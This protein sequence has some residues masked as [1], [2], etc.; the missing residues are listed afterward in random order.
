MRPLPSTVRV[1][2]LVWVVKRATRAELAEQGLEDDNHACILPEKAAIL[3]DEALS[4]SFAWAWL[5][6]EVRHAI[7]WKTSEELVDWE[8]VAWFAFCVEMGFLD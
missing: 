3:I 1:R 4:N 2:G 6:H 8:S 7:N 5:F